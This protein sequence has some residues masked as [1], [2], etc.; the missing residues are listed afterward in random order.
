MNLR[1]ERHE[2]RGSESEERVMSRWDA[3]MGLAAIAADI[4][5]GETTVRNI[6]ARFCHNPADNWAKEARVATD[7]LA[8]RILTIHPELVA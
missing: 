2:S 3:G 4:G 1:H 8:L 5:V 7:E 6:V